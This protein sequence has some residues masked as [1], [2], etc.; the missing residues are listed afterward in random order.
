[1]TV[2]QAFKQ[3]FSAARSMRAQAVGQAE[4][5]AEHGRFFTSHRFT[6]ELESA[7][8]INPSTFD[9]QER[10]AVIAA[11]HIVAVEVACAARPVPSVAERLAA[12]KAA[13]CYDFAAD[14]I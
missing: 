12:A 7:V 3:A 11:A 13:E 5:S 14:Y 4:F 6:V 1:M 8:G 10:L 2:K 9:L